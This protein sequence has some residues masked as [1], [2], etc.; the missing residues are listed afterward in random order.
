MQWLYTFLLF[1]FHLLFKINRCLL[2]SIHF[3]R[4]IFADNSRPNL[5]TVDAQVKPL[6]K[7]PRDLGIILP[8]DIAKEY[9]AVS[10]ANLGSWCVSA[11]IPCLTVFS[12]HVYSQKE[13]EKLGQDIVEIAEEY[14]VECGRK[15]VPI[16]SITTILSLVRHELK[17]P[18]T[19]ISQRAFQRP[20]LHIILLSEDSGKHSIAEM[21]KI[22]SHKVMK[23]ELK[24]S[25]INISTLDKALADIP[26]PQLL[27]HFGKHLLL[28][29]FP[30]WQLRL[31]EIYNCIYKGEVV[32]ADFINGL[33]RYANC[34][35]RFGR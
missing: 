21:S 26:E 10:I 34:D 6:P 17:K 16:F 24:L 11:G 7:L 30:P 15:E 12:P 1:V 22:I 14:F 18:D 29:G 19:R 8:L 3:C 31:T 32:Y 23:E 25:E 13:L 20:D 2:D 9:L 5:K 35:Q 33:Y 27:L 4:N 28:E